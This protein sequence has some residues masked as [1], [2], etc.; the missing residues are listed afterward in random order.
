M[1]ATFGFLTPMTMGIVLV[2]ALVIFGPGKLPELGKSLG[3]GIREFR[4][5]TAEEEKT[6]EDKGVE[7][8]KLE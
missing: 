6:V 2:T 4:S 3:N 5:A 1:L 8:K 7:I